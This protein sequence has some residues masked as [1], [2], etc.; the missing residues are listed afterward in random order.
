MS[1]YLLGIIGTVLFSAFLTGI[2]PNGK[3]SN[4]VKATTR[5]ACLIVIVAPL[6]SFMNSGEL[7]GENFKKTVIETDGGFIEYCSKI[8]IE[9]AE[10]TLSE[11][12]TERYGG[13]FEV[14]LT[15]EILEENEGEYNVERIKIT[16]ITVICQESA[17]TEERRTEIKK[18]LEERYEC[19]TEVTDGG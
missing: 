1:E 15:W 18:Y 17:L 6:L 11:H 14:F 5:L 7:F 4:M 16:K 19:F 2:L 13:N 8:S 12:L 9:N 10:K 3:T